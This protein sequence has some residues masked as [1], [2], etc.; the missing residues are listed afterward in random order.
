MLHMNVFKL[1]ISHI[2]NLK[3]M[4]QSDFAADLKVKSTNISNWELGYSY[5]AMELLFHFRKYLGLSLDDLLVTNL[6]EKYSD[7]E[8]LNILNG[9]SISG[10]IKNTPEMKVDEGRGGSKLKNEDNLLTFSNTISDLSSTI[11]NNS[12]TALR[13]TEI[14]LKSSETI[15]QL[16]KLIS[17]K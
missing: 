14:A 8:L 2:R 1:N 15:E 17:E 10:S 13:F 6:A 7:D 5:P 4:K 16:V 11:K 9:K 12:E 3:K